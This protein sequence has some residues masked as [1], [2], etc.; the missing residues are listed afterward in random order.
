MKMKERCLCPTAVG[1]NYYGGRGI[2]ICER[3]LKSFEHFL[4]D[5]GLRPVGPE[6]FSIE[7]IDV[8]GN[9]EPSNCKWAT[10]KEQANNKTTTERFMVDG[11]ELT[12]Q[13]CAKK[14]GITPKGIYARRWAGWDPQVAATAPKG[15]HG[16]KL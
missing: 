8:N 12:L 10:A 4:A 7:R 3:W 15:Y 2:T 13:E 9:Y 1:Y 5:M 6:R 11:E 14:I 16:N